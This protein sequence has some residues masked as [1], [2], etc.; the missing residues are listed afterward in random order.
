MK[1]TGLLIGDRVKDI[2]GLEKP[3][4]IPREPEK[5]IEKIDTSSIDNTLKKL[6]KLEK[7]QNNLNKQEKIDPLIRNEFSRKYSNFENN[8]KLQSDAENFKYNSSSL[9]LIKQL[10]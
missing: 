7:N 8:M 10:H 2:L 6:E 1:L 3:V 9:R 5:R 4:I